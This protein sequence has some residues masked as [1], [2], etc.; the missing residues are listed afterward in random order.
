MCLLAKMDYQP[1]FVRCVEYFSEKAKYIEKNIQPLFPFVEI[2]NCSSISYEQWS[3]KDFERDIWSQLSKEEQENMNKDKIFKAWQDNESVLKRVKTSYFDEHPKD[4]YDFVL[5]DGGECTGYDEFRLLEKRFNI[6]ALDDV[7]YAFK[8]FW[9]YQELLRDESFE[10][11]ACS[12]FVRRGFAA[13][14]RKTGK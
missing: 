1:Q 4:D 7:F 14:M 12:R 10:L 9:A 5:I 13:F 2:H 3:C 6:I 11:I 8:S